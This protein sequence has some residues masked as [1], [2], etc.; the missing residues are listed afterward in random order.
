MFNIWLIYVSHILTNITER[1]MNLNN[2]IEIGLRTT[3]SCNSRMF[4]PR[5][6]SSSEV[7]IQAHI[8][9][10]SISILYSHIQVGY[11]PFISHLIQHVYAKKCIVI[12][13]SD[14]IH[15]PFISRLYPMKP[16]FLMVKPFT[17]SRQEASGPTPLPAMWA[18]QRGL[19][20][21]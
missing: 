7:L 2:R 3:T 21:G 14:P 16:P 20:S 12:S 6:W 13:Y 8:L 15:I 4:F 1:N 17:S 9:T 10:R 11:I 5:T 18:T 19:S